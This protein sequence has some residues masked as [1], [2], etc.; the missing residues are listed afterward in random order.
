MDIILKAGHVKSNTHTRPKSAPKCAH[1]GSPR[2]PVRRR[3]LAS[4]EME[5]AAAAASVAVA[6]A[7]AVAFAIA[8]TVAVAF[9]VAVAAAARPGAS[10]PCTAQSAAGLAIPLLGEL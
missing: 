2:P 7:V 8:V 6:S 1:A 3:L 5:A 9:A 4:A 10:F